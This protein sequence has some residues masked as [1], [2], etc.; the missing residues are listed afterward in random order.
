MT[1]DS[2]LKEL[3][4]GELEQFR[5]ETGLDP[6][7]EAYWNEGDFSRAAAWFDKHPKAQLGEANRLEA[8]LRNR[9]G[10]HAADAALGYTERATPSETA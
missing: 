3:D 4:E 6:R 9:F 8:E 1:D 5:R 10:D 2:T 7:G